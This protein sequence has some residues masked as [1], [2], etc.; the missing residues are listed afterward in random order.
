MEKNGA[1]RSELV[2]P[3]PIYSPT[4]I[5]I[6]QP[7]FILL[8]PYSTSQYSWRV[9]ISSSASQI[10][11]PLIQSSTWQQDTFLIETSSTAFLPSSTWLF[12][13]LSLIF[14]KRAF[15]PLSFTAMSPFHSFLLSQKTL[16]ELTALGV[17]QFL[18]SHSL[19]HTPFVL[20]VSLYDKNSHCQ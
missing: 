13:H 11:F 6:Q 17:S 20:V 4:F 9:P 14:R 5:S 7:H 19:E 12:S 10:S 18:F 15:L 3:L 2:Q 16:K 1:L 8:L